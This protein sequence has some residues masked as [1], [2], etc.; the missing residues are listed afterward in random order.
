MPLVVGTYTVGIN[1]GEENFSNF[2]LMTL[3]WCLQLLQF[4]VEQ[5]SCWRYDVV[6]RE[7]VSLRQEVIKSSVPLP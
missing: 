2:N 4:S 3:L 7:K 1:G 6:T 5:G